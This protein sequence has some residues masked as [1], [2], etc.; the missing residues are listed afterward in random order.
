M[1]AIAAFSQFGVDLAGAPHHGHARCGAID[2]QNND[3]HPKNESS[4]YQFLAQ[5]DAARLF[6]WGRR[7]DGWITE[8]LLRCANE[9]GDRAGALK[10]TPFERMAP[11]AAVEQ[12]QAQADDAVPT[13]PAPIPAVVQG[14]LESRSKSMKALAFILAFAGAS[15]FVLAIANIVVAFPWLA[16]LLGLPLA[17]YAKEKHKQSTSK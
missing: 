1:G 12:V 14:T 4:P 8:V 17:L 9:C 2:L 5:D 3:T 15:L 6:D 10:E 7:L 16:I 13:V 11:A